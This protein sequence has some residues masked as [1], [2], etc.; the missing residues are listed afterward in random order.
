[1]LLCKSLQI[2]R[3]VFLGT[4]AD[5]VKENVTTDAAIQHLLNLNQM[6]SNHRTDVLAAREHKLDDHALVL[7]ETV[8]EANLLAVLRN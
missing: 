2:A 4:E 1:M 3:G 7:D 8:V 5:R 6:M